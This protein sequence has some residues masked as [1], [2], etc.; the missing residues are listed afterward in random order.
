MKNEEEEEERG[1]E[2]GEG[3]KEE[4]G[5]VREKVESKD[6]RGAWIKDE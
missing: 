1:E 4:E 3:E 6:G 2:E 5:A